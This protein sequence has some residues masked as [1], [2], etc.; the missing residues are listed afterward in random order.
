MIVRHALLPLS[1]LALLSCSAEQAP[2]PTNPDAHGPAMKEKAAGTMLSIDPLASCE[3]GQVAT[4]RWT[5]ALVAGGTVR[6]FAGEAPDATVFVETGIE[7]TKET[8][9]WIA[10]GNVLVAR[11]VD[12]KILDRAQAAGPG[13]P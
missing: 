7:G 10:P 9:P 8:G 11:T 13:C 1:L 4:V 2:S 3:P 12:G 5:A 6:I